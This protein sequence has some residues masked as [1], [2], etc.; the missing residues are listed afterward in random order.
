MSKDKLIKL[1]I[2]CGKNKKEGFIGLDI[3]PNSKAD[4]IASAL[5]LPLRDNSVDEIQ[6]SHLVEHFLPKEAQIFFDEI[7]RV[8]K[9]GKTAN[10]KIDKDWTKKRLFKKDKTHKY[11]YKEKEIKKMLNKF[12]YKQ[13]KDKIYFFRLYQPR[14]KIFVKLIK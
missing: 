14:R 4:I 11:R 12:S 6:S 2:G 5:D 1:D 7:Y 3:D 13:V 9:K 8:L 10:I